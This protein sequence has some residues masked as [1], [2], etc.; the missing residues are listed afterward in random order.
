MD[1]LFICRMKKPHKSVVPHSEIEYP[2]P[3]SMVMNFYYTLNIIFLLFALVYPVYYLS[4]FYKLGVVNPISID[5]AVNFPVLLSTYILGPLF[6]LDDGLYDKYFNYAIL[7]VN[8][9]LLCKFALTWIL[10]KLFKNSYYINNISSAKTSSTS[11]SKKKLLQLSFI[12]LALFFLSFIGLTGEYGLLN[13]II[14]PRSG[15]QYYRSGVGYWFGFSI[16]FLSVSYVLITLSCKKATSVFYIFFS[17]VFLAYFLGTKGVILALAQYTLIVLW[18]RKYN[19]LSR[20]IYITMPV[21]FMIMLINFFSGHAD[22]DLKEALYYFDH[23][24]HSSMYYE[25][26]FKGNIKLYNGEILLSN[27]WGLVPRAFYVDKPFIYGITIVNE[28]FWPGMAEQTITPAFGGPVEIFADFGVLGVFFSSIF[29]LATFFNTFFLYVFIKFI[30]KN[31]IEGDLRF[32]Y[33]F[34]W[35][36][37]P[38]VFVIF[39]FP[40]NLIML[41]IV[42]YII[43]YCN[44]INFKYL[45][46]AKI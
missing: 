46:L 14:D 12:F 44:I 23:F 42:A 7:M 25:E 43:K 33:L 13:W 26:F 6:L 4:N 24:Q 29:S 37:A 40:Y 5:F 35:L 22:V 9:S 2:R 8:F 11:I 27:L 36:F 10:L 16:T 30:Q 38:Y 19:N 18:L 41:V 31:P 17:Y 39:Q 45:K 32:I 20:I 21:V 34:I 15:Y 28:Y 1:L 3:I